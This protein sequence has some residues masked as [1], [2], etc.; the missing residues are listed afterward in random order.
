M[1]DHDAAVAAVRALLLDSG[2]LVRATASGARRGR[3]PRWTRVRLRPVALAAGL[4]LQV[5]AFEGR[6]VRTT[7]HDP[8]DSGPDGAA[9]AVD[10]LLA[11]GFGSWHVE[12]RDGGIALRWT[13]KD[14][15]V[16]GRLPAAAADPGAEPQAAGHDRVKPRRLP[17]DHPVLVALGLAD[18]NG[19]V[20]PS[21][22]AKY[23]QVEQFLAILD[24]AVDEAGLGDP[25][26]APLRLVDL[27]CGN[28]Y[29]TLAAV[30]RLAD[31]GIDARVVGVDVKAQA[32]T[33][34]A[35]V[36][37]TMGWSDR[38][39]FH[40]STIAEAPL[41]VAGGRP[42]VVVALH[43]CDTA[44]DD[45]LAFGVRSGAAVVL[46]A[47]CC[48]HDLQRQLTVASTPPPYAMLTRH[49]ILR[50]RVGDVLTDAL[51]AHVLRLLGYRVEVMEFVSDEHTPRNV[52]IRAM[53]ADSPVPQALWEEWDDLVSAW[54]LQPKLA[55]LLAVELDEARR[56]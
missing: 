44:T 39:G 9:A 26:S 13:S 23:I 22:R 37:A 4:R 16:Q 38:T 30:A 27:G 1:P 42:D 56:G 11:E 49:G 50:E 10:A 52:M 31:R 51:R 18:V 19:R 7:N 5:E 35:T 53:R 40:C 6:T 36:A 29:L 15:I 28:A 48:H 17:E 32:M 20:K 46:A 54:S 33:H 41:D 2:R 45:A 43:A 21:R 24:H 12:G 14:R 25:S 34:H 3:A 8:A 55:S 47:P